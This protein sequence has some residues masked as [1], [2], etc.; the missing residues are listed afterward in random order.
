MEKRNN[1]FHQ[2]AQYLPLETAQLQQEHVVVFAIRLRNLDLMEKKF[3]EVS[4]PNHE[5]Y[6]KYLTS[7]EIRKLTINSASAKAIATE[8]TK[9]G[10]KIV[11]RTDEFI[12]ASAPVHIWQSY[13]KSVFYNF[14]HAKYTHPRYQQLIRAQDFTIPSGLE[15]HVAGVFNVDDVPPLLSGKP[16]PKKIEDVAFD[17]I[18]SDGGIFFQGATTPD[19]LFQRYSINPKLGNSL[20]TQAVF[21]TNEETLSPSDLS[22]FQSSFGLPSQTIGQVVGGHI[23]TGGWICPNFP[24]GCTEANLDVQYLMAVGQKIPTSYIYY[25]PDWLSFVQNLT[26]WKSAPKV[27]SISWGSYETAFKSDYVNA[28][29]YA[30]MKLGLMGTTVLASSG[31]SGVSGFL[32]DTYG[33]CMYGPQFPASSPYVLSVG[34]TMVRNNIYILLLLYL[35]LILSLHFVYFLLIFQITGTGEWQSRNSLSSQ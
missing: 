7:E 9:L 4:D 8:L 34:G 10:A 25:Q 17:T 15:T 3:W 29:N 1:P 13:L 16:Q 35:F 33:V 24:Y 6:G 20:T 19:L 31:D 26:S 11:S 14:K 23:D 22:L 12:S 18:H 28:F 5:S 2:H 30:A 21:E 32:F 27:I